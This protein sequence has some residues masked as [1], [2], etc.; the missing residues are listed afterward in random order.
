MAESF[1]FTDRPTPAQTGSK[2]FADA[3]N[4]QMQQAM[5]QSAQMKMMDL[6]H[7]MQT[8]YQQQERE[9]ALPQLSKLFGPDDAQAILNA[10]ANMQ[11]PMIKNLMERQGNIDY[12]NSLNGTQTGGQ[13]AQPGQPQGMGTSSGQPRFQ[14]TP[15]MSSAQI[16]DLGHLAIDQAN[17]DTREI[18]RERARK[19]AQNFSE[20]WNTSNRED[21]LDKQAKQEAQLDDKKTEEFYN[22]LRN[23]SET[24][25]KQ[26]LQ[27]QKME[28]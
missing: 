21:K 17:F 12:L 27:F 7:Q 18:N 16:K 3:F 9:R 24:S 1:N 23:K 19:D 22:G 5:Q 13:G 15:N 11:G 6:Q 2:G 20:R 14:A 25:E 8:K 26:L 10:P 4:Q 28:D